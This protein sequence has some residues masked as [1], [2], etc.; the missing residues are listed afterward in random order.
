MEERRN[1]FKRKRKDKKAEE[2]AKKLAEEQ[3]RK[4]AEEEVN[5]VIKQSDNTYNIQ[6]DIS[7]PLTSNELPHVV[8][9]AD[10]QEHENVE[11]MKIPGWNDIQ[12]LF[13]QIDERQ[14]PDK[15]N[16]LAILKVCAYGRMT[17]LKKKNLPLCAPYSSYK[18]DYLTFRKKFFEEAAKKWQDVT[19][20]TF[21]DLHKVLIYLSQKEKK[22]ST[23]SLAQLKISNALFQLPSPLENNSSNV[24]T[25]DQVLEHSDNDSLFELSFVCDDNNKND[26]SDLFVHLEKLSSN[27]IDNKIRQDSG[28]YE[29]TSDES[30]HS[31]EHNDTME[32]APKDFL[33]ISQTSNEIIANPSTELNVNDI[34]TVEN[35]DTNN[36]NLCFQPVSNLEENKEN[37]PPLQETQ[38]D[39]VD[40]DNKSI[41]SDHDYCVSENVR[42]LR[43]RLGKRKKDQ[44]E[45][46]FN[47][48]TKNA[49]C[50]VCKMTQT[51]KVNL[52]KEKKNA[53]DEEVSECFLKF[54]IF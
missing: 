49:C 2:A 3:S 12:C 50:I 5:N 21:E 53:K 29:F 38:G 15:N 37:E 9:S 28:F 24:D 17:F 33:T 22:G 26:K 19:F 27:L 4:N 20:D 7:A 54:H 44:V 34:L 36:Y 46:Y 1:K 43:E 31:F 6:P 8:T 10:K 47:N 51:E 35:N 40:F 18:E 52:L 32:L 16:L 13:E 23:Q 41:L 39:D 48:F 14:L 11:L 42:P 25:V 30:C 45:E